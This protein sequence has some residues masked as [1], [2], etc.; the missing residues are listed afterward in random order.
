MH[1]R[2]CKLVTIATSRLGDS[3]ERFSNVLDA[4]VRNL[5]I[6]LQDADI[7]LYSAS[8]QQQA[9]AAI[10]LEECGTLLHQIQQLLTKFTELRPHQDVGGR[11]EV[12]YRLRRFWSSI[13]WD[14]EEVK[15]FQLR[16]ISNITKLNTIGQER[17][18]ADV[19][20]LVAHKDHQRGSS[21][22]SLSTG[23]LMEF[24]SQSVPKSS[25]GSVHTTMQRNNVTFSANE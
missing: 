21:L 20:C 25:S 18:Q 6:T 16:I 2:T 5:S 15:G 1:Q 23:K 11:Q 3:N 17:M 7:W 19:D 10:V 8:S 4:E 14:P 22:S 24:F 13:K 12:R 9:T